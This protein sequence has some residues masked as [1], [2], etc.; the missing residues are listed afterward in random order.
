M[1]FIEQ[2]LQ[3]PDIFK[4]YSSTFEVHKFTRGCEADDH[5]GAIDRGHRCGLVH[6]KVSLRYSREQGK[7]QLRDSCHPFLRGFSA[8]ADKSN[9]LR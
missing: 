1:T 6:Q 2:F 9:Y 4:S 3:V 7:I 5:V 8:G